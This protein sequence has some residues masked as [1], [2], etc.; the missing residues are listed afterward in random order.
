MSYEDLSGANLMH[1][2]LRYANLMHANLM[3]ANLK[4]ADLYGAI[5]KDAILHN[6]NLVGANLSNAVLAGANLSNA[7]LNC[8]NLDNTWL[9]KEEQIRQGIILQEKLIGWKKCRNNVLVKL[10]IPKG[11]TVFSINN[12]KCRTNKAKVIKIIGGNDN[13]ALSQYDGLFIYKLDEIVEVKD[14]NNNYNVECATGIHF[15]RTIE[16]ALNY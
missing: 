6:V 14:F 7:I 5:L 13:T 2:N 8:A 12:N 10:E 1:T 16:E 11:A 4:Y 3:F 9:D 15:F